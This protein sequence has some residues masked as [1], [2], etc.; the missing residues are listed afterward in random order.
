[1]TRREA[2]VLVLRYAADFLMRRDSDWIATQAKTQADADEID[3]A[4]IDIA[5]QLYERAKRMRQP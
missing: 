5:G 3:L 1:M 4:R 2:K